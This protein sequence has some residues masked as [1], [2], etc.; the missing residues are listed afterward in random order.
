MGIVIRIATAKD[1]LPIQHLLAKASLSERGIEQNIDN[2]LVVED[3]EK[4]IIGTVG[5]EPIEKDGLLRSLVMS[6]ESWNAKIGLD[7]I[8]LAVSY[9]KQ[10]GYETLYLLTNSSLPFFEYIGFRIL[11]ENEI[12]KHL[13]ASEHFAQY[14]DGVTKVLALSTKDL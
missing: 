3:P 5:F 9:G 13:R 8:E 1:L 11:E 4:K 2:F 7:F 14:V 10:K 6:S 12:P